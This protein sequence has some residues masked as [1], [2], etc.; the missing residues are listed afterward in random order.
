MTTRPALHSAKKKLLA[1]VAVSFMA[2]TAM[3]GAA[4]GTNSAHGH[5]ADVAH[6][7]KEWKAT[8]DATVAAP[9]TKEW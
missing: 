7:T 2:A 9:S 4:A 6:A 5:S 1:A 3:S 8:N